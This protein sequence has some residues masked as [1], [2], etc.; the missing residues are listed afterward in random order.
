MQ[1][2]RGSQSRVASTKLEFNLIVSRSYVHRPTLG[3]LVRAGGHGGKPIVAN[4]LRTCLPGG[5]CRYGGGKPTLDLLVSCLPA[6]LDVN[7]LGT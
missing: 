3:L 5:R 1:S 7:N 2:S 6:Q 4:L